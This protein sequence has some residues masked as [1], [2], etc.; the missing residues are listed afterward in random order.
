MPTSKS[1][2]DGWMSVETITTTL[3][4]PGF[5]V[6]FEPIYQEEDWGEKIT[7][8]VPY[9]VE[10]I[11][12]NIVDISGVACV[13]VNTEEERKEDRFFVPIANFKDV[14][15]LTEDDTHDFRS[16]WFATNKEAVE[17]IE[18]T[19]K[20]YRHPQVWESFIRFDQEK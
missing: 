19:M 1:M 3:Y 2:P 7:D 9:M 13:P 20:R 16:R 17:H 11:P 18:Y 6:F 14:P 5:G 15:D 12:E 4:K 10:I 8:I